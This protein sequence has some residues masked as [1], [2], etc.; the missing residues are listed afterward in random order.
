MKKIAVLNLFFTVFL[1]FNIPATRAQFFMQFGYNAGIPTSLKNF[2]YVIDRYN[3]TRT[4]LDKQMGHFNYLDGTSL[5]IGGILGPIFASCGYTGGGQK[6]HAQMTDNNG[7]IQRR[8]LW[9]KQRLF[10]MDFGVAFADVEK[11]SFFIGTSMSIGGFTVN[12]RSGAESELKDKNWEKINP[13]GDLNF[14]GGVFLRLQFTN[15]GLY[16]QPYFNFTPGKIFQ[17]DVTEINEYLNPNTYENDPTPLMVK[18]NTFGVKIGL[19]M[20]FGD[21]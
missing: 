7:I 21:N 12:T 9:V 5:S 1:L 16:I 14:T 11:G 15:P 4:Y 2:N 6:Q 17:S 10:D 3:E 8:D 20:I 19:A 18:Y 13:W